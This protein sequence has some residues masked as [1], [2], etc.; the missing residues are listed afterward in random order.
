[1]FN[2]IMGTLHTNCGRCYVCPYVRLIGCLLV[3]RVDCCQTA[4]RITSRTGRILCKTEIENVAFC[5]FLDYIQNLF[6]RNFYRCQQ[7]TCNWTALTLLLWLLLLYLMVNCCFRRKQQ[8][9]VPVQD[10][11]FS[12]SETIMFSAC[13]SVTPLGFLRTE[14]ISIET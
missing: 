8:F 5:L 4:G 1:M 13:F 11:L 10:A 7:Y 6:C 12:K 2:F 14:T 3:T 9:R